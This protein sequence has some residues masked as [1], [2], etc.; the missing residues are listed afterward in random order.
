[1]KRISVIVMTISCL[2]FVSAF[3]SAQE[4]P[5]TYKQGPFPTGNEPTRNDA[6]RDE[7]VPNSRVSSM[8]TPPTGNSVIDGNIVRR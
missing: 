1:M 4:F 3:V 7:N 2:I 6:P 5:P 8:S